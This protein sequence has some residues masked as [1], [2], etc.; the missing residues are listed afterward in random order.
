MQSKLSSFYEAMLNTII[1]YVIAFI[2]Q[3]IVYPAYGHSFTFGQNI[4]IGLIFMA[5]SFAR[6]YVIRRWFN[7]Y[8]TK[9]A[10]RLAG[11]DK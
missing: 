1:G 9:F 7:A 11:E 6:S 5:L 4:Q 8:V 2:A 3:L 10:H